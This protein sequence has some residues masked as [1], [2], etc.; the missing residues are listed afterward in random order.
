[1]VTRLY[2]HLPVN[3]NHKFSTG[4]FTFN[5]ASFITLPLF[6]SSLCVCVCLSGCLCER[7]QD[8]RHCFNVSWQKT[9]KRLVLG[10]QNDLGL[11]VCVCYVGRI[12][13]CKGFVVAAF[14]SVLFTSKGTAVP[15]TGL[16]CWQSTSPLYVCVC[17]NE[18]VGGWMCVTLRGEKISLLSRLS[19]LLF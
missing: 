14:P 16:A 19:V 2:V 15:W 18:W 3:W 12:Y 10:T 6:A 5:N 7:F 17:V 8:R 4:N 1:M 11:C 13:I 9:T